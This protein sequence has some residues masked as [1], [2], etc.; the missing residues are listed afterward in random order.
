MRNTAAK[1]ESIITRL[2]RFWRDLLSAKFDERF[3]TKSSVD[4]IYTSTN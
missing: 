1:T 2:R 3:G 4:E